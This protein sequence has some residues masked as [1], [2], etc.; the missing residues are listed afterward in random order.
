MTHVVAPALRARLE[1]FLGS[2]G[3]SF[4]RRPW[5]PSALVLVTDALPAAGGMT[6][7]PTS[8]R[9]L[10]LD[11]FGAL[12]FAV[13]KHKVSHSR[14]RHRLLDRIPKRITHYTICGK[15]G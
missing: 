2:A 14:K 7:S 6:K 9:S 11:I 1:T 8:L 5:P 13:P 4:R 12:W 15:C 10:T 3:A